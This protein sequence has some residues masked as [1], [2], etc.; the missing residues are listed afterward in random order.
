MWIHDA[1]AHIDKH[2]HLNTAQRAAVEQ[3]LTSADQVQGYARVGK[4][5]AL[6]SVREDIGSV[7]L[8]LDEAI[9]GDWSEVFEAMVYKISKYLA[10]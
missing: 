4:T 9:N 10:Q 7:R 6:Q 8:K 5:T 1:V 3:I 2:Q